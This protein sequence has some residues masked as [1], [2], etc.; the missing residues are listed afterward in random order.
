MTGADFRIEGKERIRPKLKSGTF[1]FFG[2]TI[3]DSARSRRVVFLN[4]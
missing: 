4:R 3:V 2:E 1:T